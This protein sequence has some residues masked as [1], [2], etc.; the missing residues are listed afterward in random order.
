[1]CWIACTERPQPR[2]SC[3]SV[4]SFM[5]KRPRTRVWSGRPLT[6]RP[7]QGEIFERDWS[8]ASSIVHVAVE[9]DEGDIGVG[10]RRDRALARIKAP[11]LRRIGR[12]Q[13]T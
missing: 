1:M 5:T 9:I 4:R 12:A 2:A 3:M 8:A 6:R 7:F 13:R 11:D 10:A